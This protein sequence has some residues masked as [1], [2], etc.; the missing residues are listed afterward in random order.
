VIT[1]GSDGN[2]QG[3]DRSTH[4][5]GAKI[6]TCGRSHDKIYKLQV[7]YPMLFHAIACDISN[8]QECRRFIESTIETFGASIS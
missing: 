5:P 1:G 4:P 6:A 3:F 8:E 2:K 7:E